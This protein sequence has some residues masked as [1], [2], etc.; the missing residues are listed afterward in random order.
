M[1]TQAIHV[2][3][4][5]TL[6]FELDVLE[7]SPIFEIWLFFQSGKICRKPAIY[8]EYVVRAISAN[9]LLGF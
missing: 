7:R 8:A 5:K 4:Y 3:F 9:L 2:L 6:Y 1:K